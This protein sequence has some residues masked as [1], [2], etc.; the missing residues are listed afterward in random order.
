MTPKYVGCMFFSSTNYMDQCM[1]NALVVPTTDLNEHNI[2]QCITRYI[3]TW[4]HQVPYRTFKELS[5]QG[6]LFKDIL[7]RVILPA[8]FEA[9]TQP[10]CKII[11]MWIEGLKNAPAYVKIDGEHEP[12]LKIEHSLAYPGMTAGVCCTA[13]MESWM[14][15]K[16]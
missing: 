10:E 1:C 12:R 6:E 14:R 16:L 4:Q 9:A 11:C 8:Q 3:T 15:K 7:Q 2:N 13:T 5:K